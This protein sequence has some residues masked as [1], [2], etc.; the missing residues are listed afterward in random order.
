MLG[1]I[2]I[3]EGTRVTILRVLIWAIH[4]DRMVNK[5]PSHIKC[6][7]SLDIYTH[8]LGIKNINLVSKLCKNK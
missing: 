4:F 8:T 3:S 7:F 5:R 1:T 2:L 6:S